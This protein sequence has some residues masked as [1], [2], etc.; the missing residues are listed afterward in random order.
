MKI[1]KI[2]NKKSVSEKYNI[3]VSHKELVILNSML[4]DYDAFK[5]KKEIIN[6]SLYD[7]DEYK[8]DKSLTKKALGLK[9]K[10][11]KVLK[12]ITVW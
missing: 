8:T 6:G 4:K 7:K 9:I 10:I 12:N 11:G 5:L 2:E 1:K 3:T